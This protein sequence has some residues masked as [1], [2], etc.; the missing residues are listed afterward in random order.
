MSSKCLAFLRR[1]IE[2]VGIVPALLGLLALAWL[3][4]WWRGLPTL[5]V[6]PILADYLVGLLPVAILGYLAWRMKAEYWH[7]LDEEAETD[8]HQS[9]A[10]GNRWAFWLIVKDRVEWLALFGVLYFAFSSFA[11]ATTPATQCTRDL[12][13]RWEVTSEARYV[14]RY[15]RPIWP[16][17]ASG[18]TYGIGY[19]G[20]HQLFHVILREWA[21]HPQ[22]P[23][24][25]T[26]AGITGQQAKA[27]L[28]Q[29]RDI[30][31][32]LAMALDVLEES[33]IPRYMAQARQAYG[34]QF[35][36]QP[37]GV[38]C[39]L[40]SETY[41]RGPSMAGDRRRERRFIRDV[42]L[43]ARD[44]ECV[45]LQLEASCR[46][47]ANDTKNGPGLCARRKSEA[48]AARAGA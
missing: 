14:A 29:Y 48:R 23:R 26:T 42:C 33:S 18:I 32:P 12:L 24:L 20:G 40:T 21:Q 7:D 13:V 44:A 11:G 16:E 8:L 22:A 9:A 47:W 35:D 38:Q 6:G 46:V 3:A 34:R 28:P 17:G 45:A 43:P 19:D 5:E 27:A 41:N 25:A 39:A 30:V 2:V 36:T 37:A 31:V 10:N 15:Q 4:T 1:H